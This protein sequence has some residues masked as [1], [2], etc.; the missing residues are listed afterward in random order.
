MVST[1]PFIWI[2]AIIAISLVTMIWKETPFS[3]YAEQIFLGTFTANLLVMAWQNIYSV[4]VS[5][6]FTG[7][8]I[9]LIPIILSVLAFAK[10]FKQYRWITRYPLALLV[11]V[12]FGTSTRALIGPMI[13]DQIKDSFFSLYVPNN[14]YKSANNIIFVVILLSSLSYFLFTFKVFSG[15][16]FQK[17]SVIGRYAMM[18]A[19]GYA[20]AST[21]V[22]RINSA[23]GFMQFIVK[24][25]L[26]FG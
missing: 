1:D 25:W 26:G 12:G 18:G 23:V 10:Y 17:I 24:T 16:D 9:Y 20:F 5:K 8:I 6:I 15:P 2:S 7:N 22:I 4:G 21:I 19:F 14:L 11:G 13:T 3:K